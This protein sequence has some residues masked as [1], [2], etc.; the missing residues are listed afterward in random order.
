M[1]TVAGKIRTAQECQAVIASDIDFV[2]R[3]SR[4]FA[5][6]FSAKSAA[7]PGF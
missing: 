2:D 7:E 1:L 6:R 4:D 3:Q 5:S